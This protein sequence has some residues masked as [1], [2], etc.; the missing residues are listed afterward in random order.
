MITTVS[1]GVNKVN[2]SLRP[3]KMVKIAENAE[4][5]QNT[6]TDDFQDR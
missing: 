4:Q 6:Y 1:D 2:E 5:L 3:R